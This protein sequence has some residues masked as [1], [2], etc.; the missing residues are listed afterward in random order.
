MRCVKRGD[1]KLIKYDVLDGQVR[2]TQL[3]NLKENPSEF[4]SEHHTAAVTALTHCV[5]EPHQSNL[6][7]DPR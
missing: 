6:A 4:L 3:F 5:P 2:E 7:T 1:W